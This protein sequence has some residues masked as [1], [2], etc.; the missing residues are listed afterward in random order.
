[1]KKIVIIIITLFTTYSQA[2][3]WMR[4]LEERNPNPNFFEI[5]E[6]FEEYAEGKMGKAIEGISPE[7]FE[8][9][10]KEIPGYEQF[11]RFEHFWETRVDENGNFPEPGAIGKP[12]CNNK[13]SRKAI[14]PI[15]QIMATGAL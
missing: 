11:K 1:M 4:E 10:E 5:R 7:E 6:A 2:Q 9:Y 15:H 12:I 8:K 3:V 14:A 13:P